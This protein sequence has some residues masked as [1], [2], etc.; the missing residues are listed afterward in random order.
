MTAVRDLK[1]MNIQEVA[2]RLNRPDALIEL[3][4]NRL[5]ALVAAIKPQKLAYNRIDLG[6]NA[7][8]VM[9][10]NILFSETLRISRSE[11]GSDVN[12]EF[13]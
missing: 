12:L 6:A 11:Q 3:I 10:S 5:E 2:D 9:A 13:Y 7:I 1:P 4:S 8:P